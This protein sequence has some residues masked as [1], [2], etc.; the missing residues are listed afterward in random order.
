MKPYL[1][2]IVLFTITVLLNCSPKE[3][4]HNSTNM[5]EK[6]LIQAIEKFNQAF[7]EG[8]VDLLETMI[9]DNYQHTNGNSKAFGKDS[10]INY[11]RKRKKD[12]ESGNLVVNDYIMEES[13]IERFDDMAIITA[14]IK[15]TNTRNTLLSKNEYRV[16][17][18]WVVEGGT[19]KR[20]GFHDGKI[21]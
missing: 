20:A 13:N 11:L 2:L 1:I 12:I 4:D 17:N 15:V 19:W 6:E 5:G 21:K 3:V 7:R 8:N 16:T 18:I 9:T 10:W 14:K